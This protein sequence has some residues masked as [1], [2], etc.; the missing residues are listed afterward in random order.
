MMLRLL[1][2]S[3]EPPSIGGSSTASFALYRRLRAR[4]LNVHYL[5]IVE[6][7]DAPY[8]A[9]LLGGTLTEG[10]GDDRVSLCALAA[11]PSGG[12]PELVAAID[13]LD[14]TIVIGFGYR[15]AAAAK[16]AAPSRRVVLVT[17]CCKQAQHVVTSGRV[18]DAVALNVH[19]AAGGPPPRLLDAVEAHSVAVCN[20]VVTH[21]PQT[22]AFMERFYPTE[23]GRIY[24][25]VVSFAEWI[26]ED[27]AAGIAAARP[28]DQRDINVLF[29]ASGWDRVEKNY[30]LVRALAR[31]LGDLT[32]HVIGDCARPDRRAV[33]AGF[34]SSR[35]EIFARMG[36][37]RVLVCPSLIDAAP[38][39]LFEGSVLGCNLVA[40]RNCGNW[41]LCHPDL[42]AATLDADAFADCIRLA[43]ARPYPDSRQV[44]LDAGGCDEFVALL[45]AMADPFIAGAAS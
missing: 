45:T 35:A 19:L 32:V 31:Q 36:R 42:V 33:H 27:A 15:A 13:R 10:H 28:F 29:V 25:R 7:G 37:A 1:F 26:C 18:A 4:G 2:V 14:P 9:S 24:P 6:P 41:T 38:G 30:P 3:T 17:G 44:F 43:Q 8:F 20:L 22:L 40:S 21:S 11:P 34:L 12:P 39:V 23:V 16:A 5:V